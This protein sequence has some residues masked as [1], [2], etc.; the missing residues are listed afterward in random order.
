VDSTRIGVWG[1]S[2][3][4]SSTLHLMFRANDVC[5]VGISVPPVP[6]VKNYDT[7]YQKRYVRL[8]QT[9]SAA[10]VDASAGD[11][12]VRPWLVIIWQSRTN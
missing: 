7:I 10:Y 8:P 12:R 6:D 9:D 4:G 2:G 1:W 3:G 11:I 5:K